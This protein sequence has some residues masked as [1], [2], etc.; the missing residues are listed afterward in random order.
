MVELA[1]KLSRYLFLFYIVYFLWQGVIYLLDE[2][3]LKHSSRAAS[4]AKQCAVIVLFH[5]TG[6]LIL[7][8]QPNQHAFDDRVLFTGFGGLTFLIGSILIFHLFYR[9]TCPL[10]WN[11]MLFLLD[12]GFVILQRL[13]HDTAQNQIIYA[14]VGTLAALLASLAF[15]AVSRLDKLRNLYMLISLGLLILP[16]II[17]DRTLGSL[18]WV[19]IK[20]VR[21]QP[22]ETAKF[23]YILYLAYA[24]R[25]PES[26]GRIIPAFVLAGCMVLILTIQ[27]DLGG[28]L[29]FFMAFLVMVYIATG[30]AWLFF[31]GL[32]AAAGGSYLAYQLFA[33]V[34]T[35]V[36]AWLNPWS[37]PYNKG[38]QI[39]QSLFAIGTWGLLGSGLTLGSPG[40]VPIVAS[41]FIFAAICEEFGGLFGLCLICIFIMIFYRGF[42]IALRSETPY[43][44]LLA[45]GFTSLLAFQAFL[46][47]GGVIKLI[48]LTGVTL[49]FVS[50][51]GSS[52]IVS[53]IM[54]CILQG[55][56]ASNRKE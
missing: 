56:G 21:F 53:I 26:P 36:L 6:Y 39:I 42:N 10:I 4:S 22:S 15:M 41:D 45:A 37:D 25:E 30:K 28:A 8:Y 52:V 35:R 54:I 23:F 33:H 16:F 44:S 32:A 38:L 9:K 11:G 47:L 13:N 5:I 48:P 55:I 50:A 40:F 31:C 17:G 51:G 49:P 7:A 34:Q 27:R 29:I 18:N 3:G 2:R 14:C 46:I 12:I 43:S 24:L 20:S 1:I 19:T